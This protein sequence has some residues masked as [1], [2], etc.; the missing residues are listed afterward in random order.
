MKK[1]QFHLT[2]KSH[3]NFYAA[4]TR[5]I[6]SR[7]LCETDITSPQ[8]QHQNNDWQAHYQCLSASTVIWP[9][10]CKLQKHDLKDIWQSVAGQLS[11]LGSCRSVFWDTSICES[12]LNGYLKYPLWIQC[13]EALSVAGRG[14]AESVMTGCCLELK[15]SVVTGWMFPRSLNA[16]MST[17]LSSLSNLSFVCEC[18]QLFKIKWIFLDYA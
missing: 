4:T 16:K 8:Q 11:Q 14:K 3:V 1:L 7:W 15:H 10:T 6:Q 5:I 18:S 13:V 2:Y 12:M 17:I 9:M